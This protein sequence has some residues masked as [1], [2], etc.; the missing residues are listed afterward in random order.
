MK[1]SSPQK[2]KDA[3]YTTDDMKHYMGSLIEHVDERIDGLTEVVRGMD[4]KFERKFT[5]VHEILGM[6]GQKL[7]SHSLMLNRLLFDVE[8]IKSGMREKVSVQE[9]NKLEKRLVFLESIV[10]TGGGKNS[11]T[12]AKS[13]K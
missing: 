9:F 1:K 4:E 6:H 2:K 5:E 11:K 10:L 3:V 13:G 7:D 8:E 12:K